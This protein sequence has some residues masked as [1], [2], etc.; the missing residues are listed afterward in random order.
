MDA[1]ARLA[2]R[3]DDGALGIVPGR[4]QHFDR[5]RR[6]QRCSSCGDRQAEQQRS[7][8]VLHLARSSTAA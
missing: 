2:Q 6:R 7:E 8:K 1:F 4:E 3:A 5:P